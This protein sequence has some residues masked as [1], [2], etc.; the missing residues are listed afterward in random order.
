MTSPLDRRRFFVL[1]GGTAAALASTQVPAWAAKPIRN[2]GIPREPFRLGVASGDPLP[3][4]VVLWTRLAPEPLALDGRGGMPDRQIPVQWQIAHDESFKHV[5]RAGTEMAEPASAHTVH[6][7]VAGLEP[8]RWYYYR[9]RCGSSLSPVGRTRTAPAPGAAVDQ[10][11]FAFASCQN[12]P[13]GYYTSHANLANEDL[14]V[15]FHLGDYIYEGGGQGGLGRGHLPSH[16]IRS[17]ADY[18]VRHAQYRG[19]GNLQ[20]AHA[21]FPWIVTW[22]DHEV[23]NNWADEE[24]DPD[25]ARE[26]FLKRRATAFQ[27]YWEHMPIRAGRRPTGPDMTLHRGFTFGDLA[28]FNVLDTRQY[29]SDQPACRDADC[30]EAF[31]PKRT[32][33]GDE[34]EA[35]L[36]GRLR[37][38]SSKWNVLA[39]QVPMFE[40]PNVGLPADK[41]EGYRASRQRLM[42]VF[43]TATRNP[44]VVTGDVHRNFAADLKTDWDDADAP[45]VGSEFVGTS[46]SSGGDGRSA[47]KH[48]PDPDN[49]HIKFE[50][51]GDRG[52]VRVKLSRSELRSDY[53]VVDTVER[54]ESGVRTLASFAVEA[55][56]PGVQRA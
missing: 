18:R 22:D 14:D 42:D 35:W 40:D 9:F 53:R 5:V 8:G 38:S 43:A 27:V 45:A 21:A 11:A 37:G 46:M 52:Y 29:R 48:N 2:V 30:A 32:M 13:A 4:R 17:L 23:E 51:T 26:E 39:Q 55:G 16:E 19:D 3:D 1:G 54:P 28:S 20:D 12:Y 36:H 24:S 50:N 56:N 25:T 49:P 7:D 34:Q 33:L 47:T 31:D 15:A 41:W 44:V 6:A 10:L